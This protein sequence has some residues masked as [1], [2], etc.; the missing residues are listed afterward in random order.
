MLSSAHTG[1]IRLLLLLLLAL[2]PCV[3]QAASDRLLV[4][5]A[6]SLKNALD[7]VVTAYESHHGGDVK[8]S[9]AGSSKLARQLQ[10]GAPAAVYISA[11]REWMD[12]LAE[13]GLI[14]PDSRIALLHNAIVLAAPADSDTRIDMKPGFDIVDAL[15]GA[16]LAM[17]NTEAVPAGIY[18]RQALQHLGVW[19]AVQSHVAQAANVRAA[20]ALVA[21]GEAR[22]G[23]VYASDAV[24]EDHVRTAGRFATDNHDPIVYSAAIMKSEV[25]NS[26]AQSFLAFLQGEAAGE[27]F[28]RWG[29]KLADA[30]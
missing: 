25:G 15:D 5:A 14:I 28:R 9:Y 29:F 8:V 27:I 18:G 3:T 30:D 17:A 22:L 21:R 4:F 7:D 11:N 12:V 20:L 13:D 19:Q 10:R 23:V 1:P 6:A 16:P 24:A 26:R 2:L